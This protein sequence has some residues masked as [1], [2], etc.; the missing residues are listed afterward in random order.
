MFTNQ[1]IGERGVSRPFVVG[2]VL[3][4][5]FL[6]T[7]QDWNN[8]TRRPRSELKG[9]VPSRELAKEVR[10]TLMRNLT[11]ENAEL[12]QENQ[13]LRDEILHLHRA[14]RAEQRGKNGTAILEAVGISL[15]KEET[16]ASSSDSNSTSAE[17]QPSENASAT[18][19][20]QEDR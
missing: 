9:F 3:L 17:R 11:I 2:L 8:T 6:S 5:L 18:L 7:T 15:L 19:D 4:L 16:V 12:E 10:E 14:F 13:S 1:N 20:K